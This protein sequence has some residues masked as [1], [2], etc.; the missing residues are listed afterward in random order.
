[1]G[2]RFTTGLKI[3]GRSIERRNVFSELID[4]VPRSIDS[5]ASFGGLQWLGQG[6]RRGGGGEGF[7][8]PLV[9]VSGPDVPGR[10]T[11]DHTVLA[12]FG[13]GDVFGAAPVADLLVAAKRPEVAGFFVAEQ[14]AE[15][16]LTCEI[17]EDIDRRPDTDQQ[18]T[19]EGLEIPAQLQGGLEGEA[20]VGLIHIGGEPPIGFNDPHWHEGAL[21]AGVLKRSVVL[22]TEIPFEPNDASDRFVSRWIRH[23]RKRSSGS[24]ETLA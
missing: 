11:S 23:D 13:P 18:V 21:G 5:Q 24:L 1:M 14:L 3:C 10:Q 16:E 22:D 6:D 2:M 7:V 9:P 12:E 19:A 17:F 20:E 15:G 8:C 4:L